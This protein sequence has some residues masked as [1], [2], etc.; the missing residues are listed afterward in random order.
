MHIASTGLTRV[1]V[2][3]AL[4]DYRKTI[5]SRGLLTDPEV[6]VLKVRNSPGV[7]VYTWVCRIL[8]DCQRK[9]YISDIQLN[10]IEENIG[11]CRGLG[12]KQIAYELTQIPLP[13]F[14]LM[15][16]STHIYISV[17]SWKAGFDWVQGYRQPCSQWMWDS[18]WK[19]ALNTTEVCR[20]SGAG[21]IIGQLCIIFILH[22]SLMAS[23]W[24]SDPAGE[25]S[26]AY[27]FAGDLEKLWNESLNAIEGMDDM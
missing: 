1:F 5:Q 19:A 25:R 27:D 16:I 24:M 14:H 20:T 13:Y 21:V 4:R 2:G 8:K 26:T 3:A 15:S 6:A 10:R 7:I 11:I 23:I 9:G 22:G 17:L 12:A 18:E